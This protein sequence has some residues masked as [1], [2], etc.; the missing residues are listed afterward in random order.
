V[1]A[2]YY[3][4]SV[5]GLEWRDD[6]P[7]AILVPSDALVR[8]IAAS[9]CD[10]DQAIVH[11]TVPGAEQPFAIGHEAVG[12]VID[13]GAGVTRLRP[14][15]LVVIP[16]HLSCGACDRCRDDLPLFCRETAA[17]ALAVY[18][19]PVG[20]DHGGLFS[21]LVRVPFADH[22]LVKLPPSVSPLDAVS[23]GD[24]LT[25]AYRS[26]A[27]RLRARPGSDVLIMSGGSIGL[28][29]ADIA[30]AYG[31][32]VV[33]YVDTSGER[34]ALATE[35]GAEVSSPQDFDP[36]EHEYE[37]SL[38]THGSVDALRAALLATGPGGEVENLGFHFADVPLPVAAM[39]FKCLTFRSALSNARPLIP[40]VLALVASGRI[41]PRRVHTAVLP[42]EEAAEALPSAGFKPVFVRDPEISARPLICSS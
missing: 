33:R 13:V 30:R 23:V 27:P 9:T 20:A 38:V 25:D 31:A 12:E 1:K 29:A 39:H 18:G 42:F 17:E 21:E 22:C 41:S 7:P 3:R 36:G 5:G 28:Y 34:R 14:G 40:E 19:I 11:T 10:L 32:G 8:P 37:I 2:L 4:G 16:Y 26:I 6:P 24:N 35:F 15:D